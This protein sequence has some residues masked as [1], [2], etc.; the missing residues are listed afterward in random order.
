MNIK[1]SRNIWT[2]PAKRSYAKLQSELG[3]PSN[4]FD[5]LN[6]YVKDF[7][8]AH[9]QREFGGIFPLNISML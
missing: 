4:D 2:Y 9:A 5:T 1:L 3:L 8:R 7:Y 6:D